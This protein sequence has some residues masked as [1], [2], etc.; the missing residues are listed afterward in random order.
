LFAALRENDVQI[1]VIGFINELDSKG[2]FIRKSSKEKAVNLMT[3]LAEQSGGRVFFPN[4]VS[5]LPQI[6]QE[7][8]KDLRTQYVVGYYP[9]NKAKDGSFRSVRVQVAD[10]GKRDKRIAVTRS[11]YTARRDPGAPQGRTGAATPPRPRSE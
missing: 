6:A 3:K 4:S 9:T 8:T 5:E 10:T 1:Y 7:I 2:G 11:G